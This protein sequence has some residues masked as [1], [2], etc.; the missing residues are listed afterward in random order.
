MSVPAERTGVS[1]ESAPT[2]S[3]RRESRSQ[4][5]GTLLCIRVS[6]RMSFIFPRFSISLYLFALLQIPLNHHPG[7]LSSVHCPQTNGE[8]P[9][10]NPPYGYNQ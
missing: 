4:V 2:A 7:H 5:D 1:A 8:P 10:T 3:E 6:F 9:I